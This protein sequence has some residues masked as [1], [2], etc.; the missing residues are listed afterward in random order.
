MKFE[1]FFLGLPASSHFPDTRYTDYSEENA[2]TPNTGNFQIFFGLT[3]A[4]E[5]HAFA[6]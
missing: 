3:Y 4:P 6:M 2:I 5:P 1:G